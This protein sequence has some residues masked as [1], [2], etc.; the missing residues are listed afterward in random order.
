MIQILKYER[1]L[2][3][4]FLLLCSAFTVYSSDHKRSLEYIYSVF[5]SNP[6]SAE[7]LVLKE[8]ENAIE[9]NDIEIK[10]EAYS[11][12]VYLK[13]QQGKYLEALEYINMAQ[14]NLNEIPGDE[15]VHAYFHYVKSLFNIRIGNLSQAATEAIC[16]E[17][18][19]EELND[20]AGLAKV[21]TLYSGIYFYN[22][23]MDNCLVHIKKSMQINRKLG[24]SERLAGELGNLGSLLHNLGQND[25]AYF[26]I[27]Q[28]ITINQKYKNLIWLAEN[29]HSLGLI[30]IS[31]Q[32]DQEAL[33]ALHTSKTYYEFID[34][35]KGLAVLYQR[36]STF[37]LDQ[38]LFDS[39]FYYINRSVDIAQ[40]LSDAK[41]MVACL[42]TKANIETASGN[43]AKGNKL[44]Q[45]VVQMK[46][47]IQS[48]ENRAILA[49]FEIQQKF[50]RRQ[51]DLELENQK[52]LLSG[53]KKSYYIIFL[54]AL[55]LVLI[56][57]II[58]FINLIRYRNKNIALD[59]EKLSK[60]L[61]LKNKELTLSL[62]SRVRTNETIHT[63][64][65]SL[66]GVQKEL[67]ITNRPKLNPVIKELEGNRD[68]SLWDEFEMRFKDVHNEFYETLRN[69]FPNLTPAETKVCAF[70]R[71]N[72]STK[73]MAELLH[74]S[75]ASIEVDRARI[76]K[77]LGLTNQSINLS[78]FI[79]EL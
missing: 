23:D 48:K 46:D 47:S 65:K 18:I 73:E 2:A 72:L 50:D 27:Q 74:K 67:T 75:P 32:K 12:M 41:V 34:D 79:N 57:F 53:K 9:Y 7:I 55:I 20:S 66:L 71:L 16:S 58:F 35:R 31:Q 10:A 45:R 52:I 15:Y 3:L 1:F 60:E 26:Y 17:K 33:K 44:F 61:E 42:A 37:F 30:F 63:L 40:T 5:Y 78:T 62:M 4:I 14:T 8:I 68:D 70:L 59:K 11:M 77:K 76:R 54:S 36:L 21:H 6:D 69:R 29:Y 49:I 56:L 24:N 28:A 39:A 38:D 51:M 25:S 19:F 22:K 43:H 64:V 13:S